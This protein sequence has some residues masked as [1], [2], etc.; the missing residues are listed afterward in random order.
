M[1]FQIVFQITFHIGIVFQAAS[2]ESEVKNAT[3]FQ[4]K[5]IT[6]GIEKDKIGTN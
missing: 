2:L 5:G 6:K 4:G 1:V 3:Y